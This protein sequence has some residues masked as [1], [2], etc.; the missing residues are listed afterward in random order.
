MMKQK[1]AAKGSQNQEGIRYIGV[2]IFS[3]SLVFGILNRTLSYND[4]ANILFTA[5]NNAATFLFLMST[6]FSKESLSSKKPVIRI[7]Y[8]ILLLCGVAWGIW[9][10]YTYFF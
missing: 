10:I 6:D 8:F 5:V 4:S 2:F 1:M 7:W 3:L 9:D